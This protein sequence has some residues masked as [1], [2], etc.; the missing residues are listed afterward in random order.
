MLS[1]RTKKDLQY[2][3]NH[4]YKIYN[5]MT[6]TINNITVTNNRSEIIITENIVNGG[7]FSSYAAMP[8][9]IS[10]GVYTFV[11]CE[12]QNEQ[13][14]AAY[15]G[16][17]VHGTFPTLQA[18]AE[19]AFNFVVEMVTK[20][21]N[22][23]AAGYPETAIP[24]A[25]KTKNT[26]APIAAQ[27]N[28]VALIAAPSVC[29]FSP[30][31]ISQSYKGLSKTN[32]PKSKIIFSSHTKILQEMEFSKLEKALNTAKNLDQLETAK[33]AFIDAAKAERAKLELEKSKLD[34]RISYINRNEKSLSDLYEINR[35]SLIPM[36]TENDIQ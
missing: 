21:E 22:D 30:T 11:E 34:A 28:A 27:N 24:A 25:I 9:A 31:E 7:K 2:K 13:T 8:L 3:I 16:T 19:A 32:K 33:D 35:T 15:D 1:A 4:H 10:K 18:A 5:I 17:P 26:V 36:P 20:I 12:L 29:E 6:A 23:F 14:D